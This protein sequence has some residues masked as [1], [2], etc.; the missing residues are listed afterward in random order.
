MTREDLANGR[1]FWRSWVVTNTI[2]FGVGMALFAAIAEGLEQIGVLGSAELGEKVGHVIGLALAGAILG[3]MQWRVLRHRFA[4]T[5]WAMLGTSVGLLLGYIVGYEVGGF[6]FDYLVGPA[7]AGLLASGAQSLVLRRKVDT[8]L[9][10]VTYR[11][12]A[13]IFTDVSGATAYKKRV[14]EEIDLADVNGDGR[15]DLLIVEQQLPGEAGEALEPIDLRELSLVDAY[16]DYLTEQ[17]GAEGA[18]ELVKL[19]ERLH[20][21]VSARDGAEVTA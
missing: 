4:G 11:N 6:P 16:R 14:A 12:V 7:L 5:G 18:D 1:S 10:I 2:G 9:R 8:T 15:P 13:G 21:E 3:I 20:D 19:F 17:R